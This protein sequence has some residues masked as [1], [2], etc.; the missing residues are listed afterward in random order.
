[1]RFKVCLNVIEHVTLDLSH[2][3][4]MD[5]ARKRDIYEL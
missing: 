5:G 2:F 3:R 1:M 4:M